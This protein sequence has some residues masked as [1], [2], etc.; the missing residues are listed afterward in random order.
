MPATRL[1]AQPMS[2]LRFDVVGEDSDHFRNFVCHV[3][4][5]SEADGQVCRDAQVRVAHMGPPFENPGWMC[6]HTIG[7]PQLG[8]DESN[9]VS[10]Y[11]HEIEMEYHAAQRRPTRWK[12]YTVCPHV[13]PWVAK[14]GTPLWHRFSCAGL[15][16]EAYKE[17]EITLVDLSADRLPDVYP[18]TLDTA[19][20]DLAPVMERHPGLRAELGL[21]GDGPWKAVLAGY[22]IHSLNRS[23]EEIRTTPYEA[24]S[25]DM[26]FP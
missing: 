22:V 16:I 19:Y 25:R 26:T 8:L 2:V 7:S 3:G 17:A 14:D 1:A 5:A 13:K 23:A 20:P 10:L 6:V 21:P 11:L 15:V 4:L 24:R 18:D 12:Q 9:P